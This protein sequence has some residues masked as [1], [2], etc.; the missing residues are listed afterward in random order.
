ML[1][2]MSLKEYIQTVQDCLQ[3]SEM[4]E[5]D[6]VTRWIEVMAEEKEVYLA[7]ALKVIEEAE[8]TPYEQ[9]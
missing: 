7:R 4:T 9:R 2:S 1:K 8:E 3:E 5:T 6:F